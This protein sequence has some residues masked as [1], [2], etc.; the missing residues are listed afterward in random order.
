MTECSDFAGPSER[1]IN[2]SMYLYLFAEPPT[3]T[4]TS[5][6]ISV[7]VGASVTLKCA[8][9]GDPDPT[10][11]WIRYDEEITQQ[12][13]DD[14]YEGSEK[15]TLICSWIFLYFYVYLMVL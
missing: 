3:F 6:T 4:T 13:D 11:S 8:A 14:K 7:E 5:S 1:K 9:T 10:L 12:S 2:I 15:T